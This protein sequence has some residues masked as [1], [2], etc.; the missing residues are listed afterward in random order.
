ML[1]DTQLR[2]ALDQFLAQHPVCPG[3]VVAAMA[4]D[5]AVV[6]GAAGL[7]DAQSQR[8]LHADATFRIASVTK[9]YAAA[10]TLRL[11][12]LKQIDIEDPISRYLSADIV[13]GLVVI[14]GTSLAHQVSIRHLL[15]HT[16]GIPVAENED[17][18]RYLLA[19][20][21]TVW[22]PKIKLDYFLAGREATHRPGERAVYSDLGYVTL[23]LLLEAVTGQ[24]L[25]GLYRSMLR[26]DRLG[27]RAT[28]VESLE[29]RPPASGARV[30]HYWDGVDVSHFDPTCD[31]WGGGGL[32]AD[33]SDL[34]R[35]WHALFR[36]QIFDSPD[37]LA[38]MGQ[39]VPTENANEH[40]GLGVM[41]DG[42]Y[43]YHT[44]AWGAFAVHDPVTDVSIAGFMTEH[45]AGIAGDPLG[46]LRAAVIGADAE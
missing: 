32:V 35:F 39:L 12:E 16:S 38:Q 37:T 20:P 8:P 3:V 10:V 28:Y 15:Q 22:T 41:S 4:G 17:Y 27:L 1:A 21:D 19:N 23:A 43:W 26:F 9:T 25:H 45:R 30:R 40:Y 42:R 7:A 36:G 2:S 14:E 34:C 11:A 44:G 5:D 33:A 24:P 31:L 13:D 29:P 46:A 6:C 18:I